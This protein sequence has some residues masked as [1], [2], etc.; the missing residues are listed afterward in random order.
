VTELPAIL[1]R[2]RQEPDHEPHWFALARWF[3]DNGQN[4][5]AAVVRVFWPAMRDSLGPQRTLEQVLAI[6][7][8]DLARLAIVARRVEERV[9]GGP[10]WA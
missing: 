6:A 9:R 10:G 4:D 3:C 8:Q 2:I 5:L 1:D 7:P